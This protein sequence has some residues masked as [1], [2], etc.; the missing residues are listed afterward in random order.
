M[1]R[2]SQQVDKDAGVGGDEDGGGTNSGVEGGADAP[3][4]EGQAPV[5]VQSSVQRMSSWRVLR[6]N[7]RRKVALLVHVYYTPLMPCSYSPE[8][9]ARLRVRAL[10]SSTNDSR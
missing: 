6:R 5:G 9:S 7:S 4:G 3:H 2:P 1:L 10:A 8:V